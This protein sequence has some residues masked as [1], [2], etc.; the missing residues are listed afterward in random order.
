MCNEKLA[1]NALLHRIRPQTC[2]LTIARITS[3]CGRA[4]D[5]LLVVR[6]VMLVR[7]HTRHASSTR[8]RAA[9]RSMSRITWF[10]GHMAKALGALQRLIRD[11]DLVLEVR[12]ARVCARTW[13]MMLACSCCSCRAWPQ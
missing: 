13:R 9:A 11:V 3:G 8:H 1:F 6:A 12:D 5:V 4:A 2:R 7:G 10:P